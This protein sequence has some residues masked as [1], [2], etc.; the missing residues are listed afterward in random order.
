MTQNEVWLFPDCLRINGLDGNFLETSSRTRMDTEIFLR[1]PR[2]AWVSFQ[3]AVA[4]ETGELSGLELSWTTPTGE[5]GTIPEENVRLYTQWFH[6]L[7]GK[8][9]PDL[10][11]PFD[12]P[13]PFKIPLDKKRLP[14][15]KA[16]AVWIEFRVPV[17]QPAGR[18]QGALTA[19][20]D[21][22][23]KMF[24]IVCEVE[25]FA[26]PVRGKLTA[27]FNNY[28]D[29]LSDSFATLRNNP[30]RYR[31]GSYLA[32]EQGFYR[33]SRE[34]RGVFHNLPY[35]HS[36]AMPESFF[37]ELEGEGKSIR[38]KDWSLFDA[39]FGPYFDGSAFSDCPEGEQ[40][41]EF[42]YLPFSLAWPACY[43][44]WGKKGYRTEYRR[45]L[46]EFVRHFEEK[47]WFHTTFEIFLNNKKDY[48]FFPYTI[49]EIWY[50]HDQDVVDTYYNI[51][52][53]TF[54]DSAAKFVFRMD[55]SNHYGNHFNHRFS[56]YCGMWIVGD[57]MF[58]WFP[59]SVDVMRQK[60]NILWIYG[61]VLQALDEPLLSL[62]VWP[63][64][65]MMTGVTGFTVWNTTGFGK[66]PLECLAA[67]GGEALF[68]P[69]TA[70]GIEGPL[71]S[72]RL[73]SLRSAMELTELAMANEAGPLQAELERRLNASLEIPGKQGWFRP[74]PAFVHTPPRYWD[75]DKE[76]PEA[77]LPQIYRGKNPLLPMELKAQVYD[78]LLG[79]EQKK[80]G[81]H[82]QFQ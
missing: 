34:H 20:W 43:E 57:S 71:P 46:Q 59:E 51:I 81:V 53:G 4:P 68:Y 16:G 14:D 70:F 62:W 73:K 42:A 61:S 26:V 35:R 74:K 1:T 39:H 41:V 32:V 78:C 24:S 30:N 36:G 79:G 31:D 56:D 19:R 5:V 77:A 13:L 7:H 23:E 3:L 37:P 72:I 52:K 50:E 25:P 12:G 80:N 40:P 11:L 48:R 22:G 2:N 9:V 76:V 8:L 18:Y 38:V 45:I 69:G 17:G 28:A 75:F 66:D 55:S 65:C 29:S 47:G 27:D 60:G 58:C 10:L 49:D 54:E 82:F 64:R 44:K 33:M 67:E 15:Q 21:G 6:R 63:I